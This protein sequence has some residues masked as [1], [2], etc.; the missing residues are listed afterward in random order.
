MLR[1]LAP[2]AGCIRLP[3]RRG[4]H[5]PL[6]RRDAHELQ[7]SLRVVDQLPNLRPGPRE[8]NP[9]FGRQVLLDHHSANAEP[10]HIPCSL[11]EANRGQRLAGC[12]ATF[13]RL[14]SNLSGRVRVEDPDQVEID[15]R[16]E[17]TTLWRA[18]SGRPVSGAGDSERGGH[19]TDNRAPAR[20]RPRT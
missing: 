15:P 8:Q 20:Q 6:G 4:S 12:P 16:I 17:Q 11:T 13:V 14:E 7:A 18:W 3:P 2:S 10:A 19:R 9:R 5:L 1:G